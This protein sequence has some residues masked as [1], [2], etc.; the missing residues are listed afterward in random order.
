MAQTRFEKLV[1]RAGR[2][3]VVPGVLR[4]PNAGGRCACE[5]VPAQ[6]LAP[7]ADGGLI[8]PLERRFESQVGKEGS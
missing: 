4:D 2:A 1:A 7:I 6:L 5:P 8:P 3:A